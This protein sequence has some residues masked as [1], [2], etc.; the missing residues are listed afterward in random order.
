MAVEGCRGLEVVG[1]KVVD[2]ELC[3]KGEKKGGGG[4]SE[5]EDRMILRDK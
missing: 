3:W 1:V 5:T 4:G 2:I